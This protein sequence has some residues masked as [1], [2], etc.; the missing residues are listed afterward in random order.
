MPI[1][2]RLDPETESLLNRLA[3]VRQR[4]KSDILREALHR[5]AQDEQAREAELS[6]YDRMADLVGIAQGGTD[7]LARNHKQ[8]F[9][10]IV[11]NKK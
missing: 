4:T 10:D 9:R 1:S 7:D 6:P 3:R 8:A 11:I 5:L 2:V